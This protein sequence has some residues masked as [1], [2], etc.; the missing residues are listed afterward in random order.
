MTSQDFIFF[1]EPG[2]EIGT[3]LKKFGE[4]A[5]VAD[6]EKPIFIRPLKDLSAHDGDKVVLQVEVTGAPEI[7]VCW[8][9]NKQEVDVTDQSVYQVSKNGNIH[10]LVIADVLPEDAGV[11]SCEAYNDFGDTAS[12]C[13]LTVKG[14]HLLPFLLECLIGLNVAE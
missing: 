13:T 1:S 6:D 10:K 14:E 8:I 9:H 3:V 5:K 2:E 4:K 7:D 12:S 11:W